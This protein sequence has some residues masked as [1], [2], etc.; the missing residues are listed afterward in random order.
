MTEYKNEDHCDCNICEMI[1]QTTWV[2]VSDRFPD[3]YKNVLVFADNKGTNEPKPYSIA[4]WIG[5]K[6]DFIN[7]YPSME[8]YGAWQDI[9][10]PMHSE[11]VTHWMPLPPIPQ[12]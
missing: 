3:S 12:E 9:G 1:K 11:D 7:H 5:N 10:Y 4:M 8:N 2:S 6:W